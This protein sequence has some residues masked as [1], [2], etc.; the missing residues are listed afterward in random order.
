[1]GSSLAEEDWKLQP[2]K[3]N[4]P[5]LEVDLGVG[6]WAWPMPMDYDLDGDID[7]LVACPDKPSNGVYFFENPTQDRHDKAP[8]FLPGVRVGATTH[9]FQVSY[10][11]DQPRILKPGFEFPRDAKSG[12]FDFSHPQK[13]YP[14]SNVHPNNVRGNMWRYADFDG[15]GDQDLVIGVGDWMEY[16]WDNAY[17]GQGRWHNGPL[18]GYVYWIENEGD[19]ATPKY[20]DTPRKLTAGGNAIDVYGWPS[21]NLA[22]FDGDGDLDLLCGEFLDGFTYFQN[23][24]SR[25][26]PVYAAGEKLQDSVGEPLVMHLQMIT[27]TAFDWDA[28]GDLDLIV[29][30]EDGRVAL[31]ENT[32]AL[33]GG[34]PV[35]NPPSYFQ[36]EADTLKFGALATPYAYDWDADG[37]QDILCGNTAGNIALFENLGTEGDATPMWAAPSLINVQVGADASKT[38]PFRIMAGPSGSIQGPAEA[39]WGYT[40]LTVAD[41]D[42]D[43]DPDILYNSILSRV[44]LLRNEQGRLIDT[45]LDTGVLEAPPKWYWWKTLS[46]NSL[47][48]WRTTPVAVDWNADGELDLV[49][50]DQEG[51]LTLRPG[52]GE[53]Q[54]IFIDEQNR[55]MQLN[56]KSCGGSGRI[57]L[58]VVD[59]DGDS[60]LDI[61]VNSENATWYRNCEDRDGRVVLKK[62]GNLA[63]R[64]VA[65]HTSSPAVCDF[66]ENGKPDLLVGSENGRIYFIA[67]EDCVAYAPEQLTASPAAVAGKPKFPGFVSDEFIYTKASF[68]ECHASTIVETSRGLVAAWF[69]GTRESH[70]D[71]GIWSSYHDGNGWSSPKEWANGIQHDSLRYPCWNPV[72]FQPP[73]D[74][75]TLLFFKVGPNPREWWGEMMVSYDRGR[76]FTDRRRLPEGIDGPVRCKPIL[77]DDGQTLLCGSS[78][79]YDGWRVH[80]ESIDLVGGVPSGNWKRVGP[81]NTDDR[82]NAIQPTFLVHADGRIQVL[83][84]TKESVITS[85]FSSDGGE[86]WSEMQA[87]DMPNPNSGIDVVTLQDGRQL[88]IY[89]HLGSGDTGWGR[90]GLINLAISDDGISWRKVGVLEQEEKAEF[91]YPAIIQ[92]ADGMVHLTYTWKRKL[93]KHAVIDPQ[94]IEVGE[95]LSVGNWFAE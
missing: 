6:L 74:G 66:D 63:R 76:T 48:Q 80:F 83:N 49:M 38:Q 78:T 52:G 44:G 90:R 79:E 25:T 19:D 43:A 46:S 92:S 69:G 53:A 82:F 86:T 27:P 20:S 65:G 23:V 71:V 55:P 33:A 34:A 40:T 81:I 51:Y 17:D 32:G 15:D 89:N 68:P 14:R 11:D 3:Y 77:L 35:F 67:H 85:S 18:R 13:I 41:W 61:L 60:R 10:V 91:S 70:E 84:R 56:A 21:P 4:N 58:S 57:K 93:I 39:K 26:E 72:L 30:D 47:T 22:D 88:M 16:A 9:N 8:V 37:D 36:Q 59:W 50:L 12:Q 54:R 42:N 31:V 45:A 87:I 75:P 2:L 29:G 1:M 95:E 5:G 62:I 94:E 73:G 28:D 24:G 64:N 7:L